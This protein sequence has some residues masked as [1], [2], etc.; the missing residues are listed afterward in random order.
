MLFVPTLLLVVL[1][2]ASA[3]AEPSS[4]ITTTDY[5]ILEDIYQTFQA[6]FNTEKNNINKMQYAVLYYGS[7]DTK[8]IDFTKCKAQ[9]QGS[10]F[11]DEPLITF[12][13]NKCKFIAGKLKDK[14]NRHTEKII[15]WS[16]RESLTGNMKNYD[17]KR[18]PVPS[19]G[20]KN[21][22]LFSYYSPCA[23]CDSTIQE[24]VQGCG[25]NFNR[26]IVGYHTAYKDLSESEAII[27]KTTKVAMKSIAPSHNEL[28]TCSP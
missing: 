7:E 20:N 2:D 9:T 11:L 12:D 3:K 28:W 8:S 27:L 19:A 13:P 22:Y 6:I 18:C 10:V 16:F 4:V 26:L 24:F 21:V 23:K 17:P 1:L 15:L 14:K 5:D 25:K